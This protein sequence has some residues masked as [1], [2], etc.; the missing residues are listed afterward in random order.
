MHPFQRAIN[1]AE[2][3]FDLLPENWTA[4]DAVEPSLLAG[5]L[6]DPSNPNFIGRPLGR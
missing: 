1:Q 4:A 5:M 6:S 3:A 2:S